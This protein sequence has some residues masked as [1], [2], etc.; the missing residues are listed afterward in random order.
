MDLQL[1]DK[2]AVVTGASKGIGLAVAQALAEEGARVFAA[3]REA[4]QVF[5]RLPAHASIFPVSVDL[6][7]P[8]G[9]EQLINHA[10]SRFGGVDI[11][12]NNVGN[13]KMHAGGFLETS[14]ADWQRLFDVNLMSM[15][16]TSRAALPSMIERGKGSIVNIS[17]VNGRLPSSLVVE[18]SALKAAMTNLSK[19]LA[20]E[21]GPKGIRVNTVSPTSVRT[22]LWVDEDGLAAS[23]GQAMGADRE[24]IL[25]QLPQML[26]ITLGRLVEPQEVADLV[27]FLA[28]DRSAMIT[29]VDYLIDGGS[30]K[31]V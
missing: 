31:T 30:I 18:Y 16:R 21:F 14:D 2:I 25:E 3:S 5:S 4:E 7:T 9:P 29:G 26:G 19:G 1:R 10:V 27:V 28:S 17:S 23:M 24:T 22:P 8:D 12:V 13:A 20:G 6:S 15:V 11:L